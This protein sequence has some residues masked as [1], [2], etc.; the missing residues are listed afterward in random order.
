MKKQKL[1][2]ILFSGLALSAC[3]KSPETNQKVV[4]NSPELQQKI[5]QLVEKTKKNM[6][7]VEGGSYLMGDFGLVTPE[8]EK[9]VPDS[10][11]VKNPK[12]NTEKPDHLPFSPGNDNKALHKVTLSSF[13]M[14]AYKTTL[15]DFNIFTEATGQP[16]SDYNELFTP[17]IAHEIAAGMDW[18][19]AK[20]YCQWLGQQVGT[21]MD[22]PTEA[23]WEYVA[24]NK[25][26]Y[27]VFATDT[28]KVEPEKNLWSKKQYDQYTLKYN[29]NSLVNIP[30]IGKTPPNPLGFYD[31]VTNNYEWVNDWYDKDYYKYSPVDNPKGPKSGTE[32]VL[33]ST[34]PMG[35][36]NLI[37]ADG[38]NIERAHAR[39]KSNEENKMTYRLYGVR[40][41][42]NLPHS[43]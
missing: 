8:L 16:K 41:V 13:N 34:A 42:A 21:P 27:T 11:A 4:K 38:L 31:L 3:A 25:G 18:Q 12:G 7:F 20:D 23:Q 2:F 15:E 5:Q 26:Q 40:C 30:G 35:A 43:F 19:Q 17:E 28:G 39:T 10:M 24:R 37:M 29:P 1:F 9:T 6:I 22:L 32:K 33:R 36:D 14:S